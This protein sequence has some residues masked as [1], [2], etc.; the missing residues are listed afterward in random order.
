MKLKIARRMLC[1]LMET[2]IPIR[3]TAANIENNTKIH[4]IFPKIKPP[5]NLFLH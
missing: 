4:L 2:A 1:K 3:E 5:K